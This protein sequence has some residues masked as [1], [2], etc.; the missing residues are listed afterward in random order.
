MHEDKRLYVVAK[1]YDMPEHGMVERKSPI[2]RRRRSS[3]SVSDDVHLDDI[4]LDYG[5]HREKQKR[6]KAKKKKAK[7]SKEAGALKRKGKK[8]KKS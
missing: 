4:S 5:N 1:D 8:K 7:K 3:S 6:T 2:E